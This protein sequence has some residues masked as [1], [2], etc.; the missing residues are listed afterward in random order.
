[1]EPRL[2][3]SVAENLV[4]TRPRRLDGVAL[5]PA[6]ATIGSLVCGLL[7]LLC[8]VL[9]TRAAFSD[10]YPVLPRESL[11]AIFPSYVALGAYLIILAMV[12]DALDGR[13]ARLTRRTSE[14]GAQLDSIADVVSF[15]AA[16]VALYWTLLLGSGTPDG[17]ESAVSALEWR[18]GVTGA[19]VYAS[20]AAIRLARYNAENVKSESALRNF[21]GLPVPGAAAAVIALL[22]LHEE[23]A[24]GHAAAWSV[25]AV[26][27]GI[28]PVL[29]A[30]GLLMVS[31]I[32][33]VHVVNVYVRRDRPPIHLVALVAL[34]ALGWY[35]FQILLVLL[36]FAYVISGAVLHAVRDRRGATQP[37]PV[38]STG[39]DLN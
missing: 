34:A 3:E 19:L 14:F 31:R 37:T 36:A 21:S 38:P 4:D 13:L 12:F 16:P 18:L 8:C 29:L 1:M 22:A 28:G 39:A 7:A 32:D 17:G 30:L 10:E 25:T 11:A 33:Y 27:W 15:G 5:L 35:S 9:S 23:L 24:P 6:A 2:P 20:C 26:R